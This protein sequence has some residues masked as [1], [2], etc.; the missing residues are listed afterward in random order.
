MRICRRGSTEDDDE[1]ERE[2]GRRRRPQRDPGSKQQ[3]HRAAGGGAPSSRLPAATTTKKAKPPRAWASRHFGPSRADPG[4]EDAKGISR[5]RFG[6]GGAH[7]TQRTAA[8]GKDHS[9]TLRPATP[10]KKKIG[11]RFS[12]PNLFF[13]FGERIRSHPDSTGVARFRVEVITATP[14]DLR[15]SRPCGRVHAKSA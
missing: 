14:W 8:G 5:G 4:E 9:S 6:M 15:R 10:P 13:L 12:I 11:G 1:E 3:Q 2:Q 7:T